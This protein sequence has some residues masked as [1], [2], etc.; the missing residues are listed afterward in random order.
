MNHPS[1]AT[2]ALYAGQELGLL[3]RWRTR[4]HLAACE[5]CRDEVEAYCDLRAGLPLMVNIPDAG[6][7]RLSAEMKANIRL[8]LS[9]GECVRDPQPEEPRRVS[10]LSARALVACACVVVLLTVGVL[11]ERPVPR[12]RTPEGVTLE[13]T[14]EGIRFNGNGQSLSLLHGGAAGESVTYSVSAQGAMRARYVDSDTGYVTINNVYA[15]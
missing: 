5:R 7:S 14:G 4:R 13:A 6:W 11:L 8:G 1:D 12:P 9:A 15:Q 10:F 2:L 3:A